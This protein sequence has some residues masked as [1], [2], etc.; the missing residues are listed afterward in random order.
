[1]QGETFLLLQYDLPDDR[2][3]IRARSSSYLKDPANPVDRGVFFLTEDDPPWNLQ[4]VESLPPHGKKFEWHTEWASYIWDYCVNSKGLAAVIAAAGPVEQTLWVR[5]KKGEWHMLDTDCDDY[6]ITHFNSRC[7]A[8]DSVI[9]WTTTWGYNPTISAN[10]LSLDTLTTRTLKSFPWTGR[11]I[12]E[13]ELTPTGELWGITDQGV[14]RIDPSGK[15]SVV[16]PGK[17]WKGLLEVNSHYVTFFESDKDHYGDG[18]G[19]VV[20]L[21]KT[22][23]AVIKRL[24]TKLEEGISPD[25]ALK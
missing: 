20:I 15:E 7:A 23:N 21:D 17:R 12:Y 2:L 3:S 24:P 14:I 5:D 16:Y 22:T 8:D 19:H 9:Y 1:M 6:K 4:V 13:P 18:H 10:R 11:D 25:K